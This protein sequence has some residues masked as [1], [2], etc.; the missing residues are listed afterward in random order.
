MIFVCDFFVTLRKV[1]EKNIPNSF[2]KNQM[3]NPENV[4]DQDGSL[5]FHEKNG[6]HCLQMFLKESSV[7]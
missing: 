7:K 1:Y 3:K 5:R 2:D 6:K 4:Q